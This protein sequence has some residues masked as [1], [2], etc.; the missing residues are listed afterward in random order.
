M[1]AEPKSEPEIDLYSLHL[2]RQVAKFRG[3]TAASKACGLS[4]SALTR[5]VQTIEAR[6]GIKVFDRT[7]RSVTITE[8]GAV[9]LRE[10]EAIPNILS[11]AMRRIREDYLGKRREIRIGISP[12]LALAHIAGIFHLQ[13]RLQP[14]VK[15]LVSQPEETA[16]L[17]QVGSSTLDLGILTHPGDVPLDVE[18]THRMADQFVI[19]ASKSDPDMGSLS[20]LPLFRKWATTQSWLLPPGKSRSRQLIEDWAAGQKVD[21]QPVM[22]LED[23]DLMI[24][25]VSMGMG[26]AFIP[27]RSL[28]SFRRK[29][30]LEIVHPPMELCR[31]LI[32]ISPRHS[33]CPE[34]VT[35]FVE[36]ILF[37]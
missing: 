21:L 12:D 9:L 24:Q 4:Q 35:R 3:F 29:R 19:V 15:I 5:Q 30:L 18:V 10:T 33:K 2:L 20:S 34:H 25:F 36:G 23:F 1:S 31:Q 26:V 7:T 13:Q 8:P 14:E 16:L 27:R 37:S 11:G 22:E 6:L 17:R 28:S 32:V